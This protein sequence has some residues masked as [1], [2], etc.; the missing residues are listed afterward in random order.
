M[1][2]KIL[3]IS[4]LVVM[5][6]LVFTTIVS[7][8]GFTA[9]MTPSSTTVAEATEFTVKISVSNL[10]VGSNGINSLTGYLKY[11]KQVFET[12]SESSI[13]GLNNWAPQFNA[14][15]GKITLTKNS[16]VKQGEDVFQVTFKTLSGVTGKTGTISYQN[17]D[18]SNSEDVIRA[19]DI[20]TTITVGSAPATPSNATR[21]TGN[22]APIVINPTNKAANNTTTNN[23]VVNSVVPAN[24]TAVPK[25][26]TYVNTS[27]AVVEEDIPYT[28]VED[29]I[30]YVIIVSLAISLVFY[31]KF[32][33]INKEM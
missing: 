16:F 14:D 8:L 26:S 9:T 30:M 15:N 19:T 23:V 28:G 20:S 18:A 3:K 32:E 10:D 11:D 21:N 6:S 24:N 17:I 29:T 33:K 22:A 2:E 5:L 31:I 27:N 12:I 25:N 7:A 1:K 4:V 13:E